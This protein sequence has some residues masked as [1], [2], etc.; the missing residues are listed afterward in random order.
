M[1]AGRNIFEKTIGEML[2]RRI[3]Y[4]ASIFRQYGIAFPLEYDFRITI[5]R[6]LRKGHLTYKLEMGIENVSQ[7]HWV[8]EP[9]MSIGGMNHFTESIDRAGKKMGEAY[10]RSLVGSGD[11]WQLKDVVADKLESIATEGGKKK[12]LTRREV[13]EKVDEVLSEFDEIS[14]NAQANVRASTYTRK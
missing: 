4:Y 12:H 1:D 3:Q 2:A 13:D 10:V 6:S 7:S 11:S 8:K 9:S 5:E 14:A